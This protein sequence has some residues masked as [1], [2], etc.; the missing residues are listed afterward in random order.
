[1]MDDNH[2]TMW[3]LCKGDGCMCL[4]VR[5]RERKSEW[6]W[7]LICDFKF[8]GVYGHIHIK[9]IYTVHTVHRRLEV[10][11]LLDVTLTKSTKL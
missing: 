1:M 3:H 11:C 2:R 7:S 9:Y 6:L 4:C 10:V 8:Y 5:D